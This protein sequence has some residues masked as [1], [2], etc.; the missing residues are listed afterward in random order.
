MEIR[1]IA[2]RAFKKRQ[3]KVS[4]DIMSM[5]NQTFLDLSY[6]FLLRRSPD[7]EGKRHFLKKLD[8]MA[9][10]KGNLLDTLIDSTEFSHERMF[11]NLGTSLHESRIRF[12]RQLPRAKRI[13]DLGGSC[14]DNDYGA[15]VNLGYPY[16]FDKLTIVDLPIAE[17]HELY[18]NNREVNTVQSPLGEVN[19]LYRSMADLGPIADASVDLV[20]SGQSIE[21]VSYDD[22]KKVYKETLRV[23]KPG[24]IFALDTP[25]GRLTRIQQDE[26][27]DPDHE[28][29]YTFE[30][31]K[32]SLEESG[33]IILESKGLNYAGP[34]QK[35]EE[36]KPS[37]IA[38]NCGVYSDPANCYLL[39][40]ICAKPH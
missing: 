27:I 25:N 28:I 36:F 21:H 1:K 34:I 8:S 29:E 32:A 5:D 35:R 2:E 16:H 37:S 19:Y 17:R 10:T 30:Q 38:K 3:Q 11:T 14:Q 13:V 12:V 33:F 18:Q 23:L 22:S 26:F 40:F 15:L 20:Y 9:I 31:L 7:E 39:G 4:H 6:Q 24:G